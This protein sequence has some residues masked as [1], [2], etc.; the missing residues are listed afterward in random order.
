VYV[1]DTIAA[2]AT[3][4]GTG[5]VAIV[6]V[7]GPDALDVARRVF[8][9]RAPEQ[10]QSHRLYAGDLL[11]A[12]ERLLDRG[13]GVVMRG[14]RSYT[15]EDVVE[16]HCHGGM[17]VARRLF[18][19]TL[20]AGA[21]AARGGE[22]TLRAFVNGKLDLAQAES[23]ADLIAARSDT[24]LRV[25]AE[26]LSGSLSAAIEQWRERLIGIAARL[27]VSIDFSEEDVGDLDRAGLEA[28]AT[29]V[30]EALRDLAASYARGRI[31]REGLRVAIVG[32]PNAGKS[33]WLNRLL[34]ADRA[35]VTPLPGTTRDVIEE[36]IDLD[37]VAVVF[38]DTAGIRSPTDEVER[39]GIDRAHEQI[40]AA[41]LAVVVLDNGREW[42]REDEEALNAA[43]QKQH[44]LLINKADLPSRLR[45]PKAMQNGAS[46]VIGSALDGEG[47]DRL[48]AEIIRAADFGDR[49]PGVLIT[50]ERHRRAIESAAAAVDRA[51]E[52]LRT[53][54]PPDVIAV[55]VMTALD[56]LGEIVGRTSPETVLDRIFSEFCIGK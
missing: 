22:F 23:V 7:S 29:R 40:A 48:R 33:S 45:I 49:P 4:G 38:V 30:F 37:G 55:D 50:R 52:A 35:I 6:R 42:E 9:G 28:D 51:A 46:V 43:R 2:I 11:D 3:A 15:G 16:L 20:A 36:S 19:A 21:R 53:G 34:G 10:W 41:D 12:S 17:L 47:S 8:R 44:I 56:H 25:A 5:A 54:H 39:I 26:Q 24:A 27:E 1:R 32:K 31:V 18:G 14:P 13:L